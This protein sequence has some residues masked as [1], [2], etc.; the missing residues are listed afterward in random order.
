MYTR[1]CKRARRAGLSRG[2]RARPW[3]V[4]LGAATMAC[5]TAIAQGPGAVGEWN[6]PPGGP[7]WDLVVFPDHAVHLFTGKI[8]VF[9]NPLNTD[10]QLWNPR[11]GSFTPVAYSQHLISCGGNAALDDGSILVAGGGGETGG[12]TDQTSIFTSS[13]A[14]QP[15]TLVGNLN[16]PRWYP[17]CTTLRDGKVLVVTGSDAPGNPSCAVITPEIYDPIADTWTEFPIDTPQITR[18]YPRMF[19]VPDGNKVLFVGGAGGDGDGPN[20]VLGCHTRILDLEVGN[21]SW[22]YVA[23]A[24]PTVGGSAVIYQRPTRA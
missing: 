3:L 14:P 18:W 11:D 19:V 8:L 12:A 1:G 22:T 13:S 9:E 6:D 17:T 10:P 23:D 24:P 5:S 20:C 2:R 15:W 7:D 4:A 21:E 16:N